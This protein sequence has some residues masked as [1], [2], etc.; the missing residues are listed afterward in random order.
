MWTLLLLAAT[1]RSFAHMPLGISDRNTIYSNPI[2][3]TQ[4]NLLLINAIA[5][6]AG[7]DSVTAK[8]AAKSLNYHL[9][10]ATE[11][12]APLARAENGSSKRHGSGFGK[13]DF[14]VPKKCLLCTIVSN[15]LSAFKGDD[16]CRF[17]HIIGLDDSFLSTPET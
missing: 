6:Y 16:S 9:R 14:N 1:V 5:I 2:L 3:C 17:F 12:L 4:N 7:I 13:P 11:G 8:I 15:D 10:Y